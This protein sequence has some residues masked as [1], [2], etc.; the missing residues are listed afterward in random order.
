MSIESR[1]KLGE[2]WAIARETVGHGRLSVVMPVYNLGTEI[3]ANIART[4]ELFDS[5]AL[6]AELVPVDDGST[7]STAAE[8]ARAAQ[9]KYEHV[10]VR[11]VFC[12]KNGGKGAAL[13]AGFE[14]STGEFV[15]L[16]DGDLDIS[17]KQTPWFFEAMASKGADIVIRA[18]SVAPP[19]RK[20]G[21]LHDSAHLHR[22]SHNRHADRHEALQT[23]R[24]R[25]GARKDAREDVRLRPGAPLYRAPARG[26]DRGGAGRHP[27]RKQVRRAQGANREDDGVR[28]ARRLL[29]AEGAQVLRA[30]GGSAEARPR[31]A[32]VGRD[33]LPEP[34]LDARRVPEG[35]RRADVPQLR[36]DSAAGR[37]GRG[38]GRPRTHARGCCGFAPPRSATSA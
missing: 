24:A 20:L 37:N 11:P 6:R 34:Q 36:G 9:A 32:R 14:A 25:R 29:Q 21:L 30:R 38:L 10:V 19:P 5:H 35:P 2:K 12:A 13:R 17:P 26:E 15:M 33:S 28:L 7:D 18:V 8:L 22:S 1:T 3:A 31:P 16:L 4:A 27:F 23:R